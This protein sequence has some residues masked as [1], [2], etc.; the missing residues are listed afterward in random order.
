MSA[1]ARG[2]L[3]QVGSGNTSPEGSSLAVAGSSRRRRGS[4]VGDGRRGSWAQ[5][6][7]REQGETGRYRNRFQKHLFIMLFTVFW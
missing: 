4:S 2:K 5:G 1:N 7:G 6:R 3:V